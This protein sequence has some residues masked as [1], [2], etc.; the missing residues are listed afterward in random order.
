MSSLFSDEGDKEGVQ[1][2]VETVKEIYEFELTSVDAGQKIKIIKIIR[3]LLN[4]GLK[5][6]KDIVDKAPIIMKKGK[7]EE[8]EKLKEELA[9]SGCVVTLK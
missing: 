5:E 3:E 8:G 9:K 7:K 4:L 2:V 6:A 1:Q